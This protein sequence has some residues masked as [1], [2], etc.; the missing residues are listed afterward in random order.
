MCDIR[1]Y[2]TAFVAFFVFNIHLPTLRASNTC[3]LTA[4]ELS[5]N[6]AYIWHSITN[7]RTHISIS[8]HGKYIHDSYSIQTR[9]SI[10]VCDKFLFKN[11]TSQ[12]KKKEKYYTPSAKSTQ[13]SIGS[14][15]LCHIYLSSIS[16][17]NPKPLTK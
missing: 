10:I 2:V 3:T 5:I 7:T 8:H 9:R 17:T 12:K 11:K 15:V 16:V 4:P 14:V 1:V 6:H 13:K